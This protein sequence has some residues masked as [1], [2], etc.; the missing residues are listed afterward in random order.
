MIRIKSIKE[1]IIIFPGEIEKW[2]LTKGDYLY[3]FTKGKV[4]ICFNRTKTVYS[5]NTHVVIQYS[6]GSFYIN[7]IDLQPIELS[8][9]QFVGVIQTA[10]F[11]S[12]RVNFNPNPF[13]T[14]IKLGKS[15]ELL[16]KR[17]I[18]TLKKFQDDS[19]DFNDNK[20]T[21]FKDKKMDLR[22]I[23]VNRYIRKNYYREITLQDLA[24]LA[25][26]HPTYLSNMY[27]KVFSISPIYFMNQLRIKKAKDL[28]EHTDRTIKDIATT[29]G[30]RSLSQFSS[31]FKRSFSKSPSIYRKELYESQTAERE[32]RRMLQ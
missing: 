16:S 27:S 18:E 15:N 13:R 6:H 20:F 31:I 9:F 12:L 26:V 3:F 29:V 17:I 24:D 32:S 30:Y 8:S 19:L 5:G 10:N 4:E 21:D 14:V 1:R 25:G 11:K 22:L 23:M 7:N 28:L 2:A